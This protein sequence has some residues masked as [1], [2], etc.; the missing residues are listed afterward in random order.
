MSYLKKKKRSVFLNLMASRWHEKRFVCVLC[1]LQNATINANLCLYI[2][3]LCSCLKSARFLT[4]TFHSCEK[5]LTLLSCLS[6]H[7]G[8]HNCSSDAD[9]EG[10]SFKRTGHGKSRRPQQSPLSHRLCRTQISPWLLTNPFCYLLKLAE[11][12]DL[13][14]C[15]GI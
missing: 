11:A 5:T 12:T 13:M 3:M 8:K 6:Q 9:C 14:T 4:S 1:W 10:G 15:W 7:P 2:L